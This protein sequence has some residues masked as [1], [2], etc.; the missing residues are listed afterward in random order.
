[1]RER[2]AEPDRKIGFDKFHVLQH[3]SAAVEQV[4]RKES[5]QLSASGDTTLKRNEVRLG[6]EPDELQHHGMAGV[7]PCSGT[8]CC[9]RPAPVRRSRLPEP[10]DAFK[11]AI[12]FQL[13]R[14]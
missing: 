2:I 5:K 12:P 3:V 8:A 7:S 10:G 6:P 11:M 13:R 14:T 9:S 1:M 4:R